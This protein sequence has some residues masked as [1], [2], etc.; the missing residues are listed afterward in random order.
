MQ[1]SRS[2]SDLPSRGGGGGLSLPPH[3][4]EPR[5]GGGR[6]GGP[7][8]VGTLPQDGQGAQA[9]RDCESPA[10]LSR[11]IAKRPWGRPRSFGS[12][13]GLTTLPPK[14]AHRVAGP[15]GPRP[16]GGAGLEGPPWMASGSP[17][18]LLHCHYPLLPL[19]PIITYYQPGSLQMRMASEFCTPSWLLTA[20][21]PRPA[22][23]GSCAALRG[24]RARFFSRAV[25]QRSCCPRLQRA[26]RQRASALASTGGGGGRY[27]RGCAR[28]RRSLWGAE[29]AS[30]PESRHYHAD[31]RLSSVPIPPRAAG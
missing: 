16:P 5:K 17:L 7:G 29:L 15:G 20:A 19:L 11:R 4:D 8:P 23:S 13:G 2:H 24:G 30:K 9:R 21:P 1:P 10:G 28:W 22:G 6:R 31:S 3:R 18:S 12:N 27:E 25:L 26:R 14:A